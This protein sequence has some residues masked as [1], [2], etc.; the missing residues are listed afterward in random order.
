MPGPFGRRVAALVGGVVFAVM[1]VHAEVVAAVER[2]EHAPLGPEQW[3]RPLLHPLRGPHTLA[4]MVRYW[5]DHDLSHRRQ[6][7]AALGEFA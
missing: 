7:R 2:L 4:D 3:Q 1:P 6:W 5:T